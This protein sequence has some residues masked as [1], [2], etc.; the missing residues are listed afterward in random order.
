M[1]VS[2]CYT[3]FLNG[4]DD[5]Q[6]LR[7]THL[8]GLDLPA[9]AAFAFSGNED[10]PERLALYREKDPLLTDEPLAYFELVEGVYLKFG[11]WA[12]ASPF[13]VQKPTYQSFWGMCQCGLEFFGEG[14]ESQAETAFRRAE[15]HK[16]TCPANV[17]SVQTT[18]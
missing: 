8:K 7:D 4:A 16:A 10:C 15:C 6:W 14:R 1:T 12:K 9:F 2:N 11:K 5:V 13:V 17:A 3:H 18:A